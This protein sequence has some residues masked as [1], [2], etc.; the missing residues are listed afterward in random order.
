MTLVCRW[1][2][3]YHAVKPQSISQQEHYPYYAPLQILCD[4]F[5]RFRTSTLLV[6]YHAVAWIKCVINAQR[7]DLTSN[8]AEFVEKRTTCIAHTHTQTLY[9]P[10][11]HYKNLPYKSSMMVIGGGK[12]V[13]LEIFERLHFECMCVCVDT[14]YLNCELKS[15]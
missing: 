15:T 2:K 8:F 5:S 13:L 4:I 3:L 1:R 12:S 10:L 6:F 7:N 11:Q 14:A 9:P